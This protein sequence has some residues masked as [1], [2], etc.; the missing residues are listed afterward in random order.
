MPD[1]PMKTRVFAL[2]QTPP[3][4]TRGLVGLGWR[5]LV[6]HPNP[7]LCNT[8]TGEKTGL[9]R[10]RPVTTRA[11]GIRFGDLRTKGHLAH[12]RF[13]HLSEAIYDSPATTRTFCSD[14]LSIP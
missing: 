7:N 8:D 3:N 9:S 14:L 10:H 1:S 5:P 6:R 11:S 12:D 4:L 13:R 2:H